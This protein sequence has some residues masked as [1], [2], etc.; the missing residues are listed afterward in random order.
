MS[1]INISV[2]IPVYNGGEGFYECLASIKQSLRVPDEIVVVSDGDTDGSWQ[3]AKNF[4]A[5]VLRLPQ[6]GGPARARN[7]GA[8]TAHGDIIFFMDADVTLHP[9]TLSLVEQRFQE[10]SDLAALIGSYDDSPGAENFLSQYKNLFHH[11]THQVSSE[12]ASTFWGAC[13]AIRRSVFLAV[14]GF[15]EDY[16]KPC[17]EDIELGYRLK[18]MG[19]DIRL[20]K[21]IQ[22]K[23]L[24]RWEPISL[25]KA[26]FFYRALPWTA[27]LLSENRFDADLNLSYANRLSVIGVFG[28]IGTSLAGLFFPWLWWLTAATALGLLLINVDVY[29]FFYAK[30][31]LLFALRVIPWHW[32]YFFYG[33]GAFA[34]VLLQHCLG[35]FLRLPEPL[36]LSGVRRSR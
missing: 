13:G 9:D 14:G 15:D 3:V 7:I 29:R 18:Q 31:G 4:G 26:D 36:V 6:S 23:H 34:F 20:F 12:I 27:L 28:L 30:R 19:Y 17:I 35:R 32:F 1:S 22:V 25:L 11:Y 2:V 10:R 24:K 33:G 8:Q 5:M 21:D 16:V